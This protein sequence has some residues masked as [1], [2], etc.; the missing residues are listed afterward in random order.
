[1]VRV[2]PE[3]PVS[4]ELFDHVAETVDSYEAVAIAVPTAVSLTGEGRPQEVGGVRVSSGY[5]EVLGVETALGTKF[6]DGARVPGNDRV[7][8]LGHGLWQRRFGGDPGIVG[9][10]VL[11]GR[12]P[13]PCLRPGSARDRAG[14]EGL[15]GD[16]DRSF[17]VPPFQGEGA[18]AGRGRRS[19]VD[20]GGHA[21]LRA[22]GGL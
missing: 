9:R 3:A 11:L 14:E 6:G 2:L 4:S 15:P 7:A 18:G 8:I 1:M 19:R 20:R 22:T 21:D 16:G 10:T 12:D 5:F 13:R 17:T